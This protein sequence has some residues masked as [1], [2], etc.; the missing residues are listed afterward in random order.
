MQD[1]LALLRLKKRKLH[2]FT[3]LDNVSGVIR[4]KRV[5]LLLGPPGG[6][7]S[8]LLEALAG[9]L[10]ESGS[11]VKVGA[12]GQLQGQPGCC[13]SQPGCCTLR[14]AEPVRAAAG[15]RLH[16]ASGAWGQ[17]CPVQP[18]LVE[19]VAVLAHGPA[20]VWA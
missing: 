6:G 5:C 13:T 2:Q 14:S 10:D 20:Y 15:Q 4:P 3:I 18:R 8:T 12:P 9:K 11:T 17:Q 19:G 16:S 7:K 1:I